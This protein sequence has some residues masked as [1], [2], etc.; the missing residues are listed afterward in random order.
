[1]TLLDPMIDPDDIH[2]DEIPSA[3]KRRVGIPAPQTSYATRATL[4]GKGDGHQPLLPPFG[5]APRGTWWIRR[6]FRP[7]PDSYQALRP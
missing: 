7:S 1:M 5:T 4:S 3:D 2:P 6:C